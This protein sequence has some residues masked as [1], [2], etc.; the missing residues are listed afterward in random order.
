MDL[1]WVA[2]KEERQDDPQVLR[3]IN[4]WM[5]V[6]FAGRGR[7]WGLVRRRRRFSFAD[8]EFEL[9]PGCTTGDIRHAVGTC[10]VHQLFLFY[11]QTH[12]GMHFSAHLNLEEV[13]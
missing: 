10:S 13:I 7:P 3:L 4:W 12:G 5:E 11:S 8:A 2:G 6:P 9:P 1:E